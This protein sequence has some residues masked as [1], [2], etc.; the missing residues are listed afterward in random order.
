MLATRSSGTCR[1]LLLINTLLLSTAFAVPAMAQI[2]EVVVTAQKRTEDIQNVPI[3]VTAFT[4]ED[5]KTEQ[6]QQ[7]KD[8]Q[9]HAPN[10]TYT[11]SNFGTADIQI[12]GIGIT[13]VG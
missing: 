3:A 2:E 4:N 8:L 6:I 9:F 12:R 10:L 13:A 1:S 7:F 5:L 11:Q